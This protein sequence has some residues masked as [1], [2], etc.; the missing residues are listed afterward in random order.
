MSEDRLDGIER[1]IHMRQY[2]T[3]VSRDNK[4][5]QSVMDTETVEFQELWNALCDCFNNVYV[6]YMTQYGLSQWESIYKLHPHADETYA[7]RRKAILAAF[8]GTRPY[9]LRKF[10]LMLDTIYGKNALTPIVDGNKYSCNIRVNGSFDG[11]VKDVL[12]FAEEIVPKNLLLW[13]SYYINNLED[14]AFIPEYAEDVISP[15][16]LLSNTFRDVVPYG[17]ALNYSRYDGTVQVS[18]M[19]HIG[20]IK[21]DG[22]HKFGEMLPNTLRLQDGIDWQFISDGPN[23]FDGSYQF[24]GSVIANGERPWRLQYNDFMDELSILIITMRRPDG[25][26]EL[27][28][29]VAVVPTF[30]EGI[31][32]CGGAKFGKTQLPIDNCGRMEVTRSHRF[33]GSV[34][35]GQDMNVFDGSIRADGSFR[36]DGGGIHPRVDVFKDDLCGGLNIVK[37]KKYP[38]LALRYPELSDTVSQPEENGGTVAVL[39]GFDDSPCL[40]DKALHFGD[41]KADGSARIGTGNI[42]PLDT[43]GALTIIRVL[44]ANGT[45]RYDGGLSL[46]I[47]A[48]GSMQYGSIQLKGGNQFGSR[49]H[50]ETL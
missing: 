50:D 19:Y 8:A 10:Q 20:N 4:D 25:T 41:V 45:H 32:A 15:R 1:T 7:D 43:G 6:R 3:P 2:L 34:R 9:T 16:M 23:F 44:T 33:D 28:D 11:R 46:G 26:T 39:D 12:D 36:F 13:F 49:R 38:P 29:D 30:G 27:E 37:P 14:T 17:N 35:Y 42:L 5:I 21:A 22:S 47:K 24:D 18:D 48:D 40:D 31:R